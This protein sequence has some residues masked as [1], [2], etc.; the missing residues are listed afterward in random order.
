MAPL[1]EDP[2]FTFRFADDRTIPRI[3]VDGLPKGT[4]IT[5][6]KI[7]AK[8]GEHQQKLAVAM[9]GEDGWV[10]LAAPLIVRAGDA[11]VALPDHVR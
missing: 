1:Y 9:V 2:G 10:D 8:T 7:D 3:H 5:V 4:K 6:F 11:F